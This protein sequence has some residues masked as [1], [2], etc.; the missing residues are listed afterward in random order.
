MRV[1][2]VDDEQVTGY[3][4]QSIIEQVPGTETELAA[5]GVEA[6]SRAAENPPQAVFLDIDLPDINGIE[7]ARYLAGRYLDLSIVFATAYPDH[8]LEAFEF[9]SV[10]Y[11]LKPFNEERIKRTVKKIM[12]ERRTPQANIA[13]PIKTSS[14][15]VFLKPADILYIES[16]RSRSIIKTVDG[17]YS[18][19]EGINDLEIRLQPYHFFRCHRSYLVNLKQVKGVVSSGRTFQVVLHSDD[20]ILLSR[21]QEKLLNWKLEKQ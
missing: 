5:C 10:D 3:L 14:Q 16:R 6:M 19:R 1:L 2:I 8:A 9:Y 20:T 4:L 7:L 18:A 15:Q 13:I 11:I 21:R 12:G 17:T